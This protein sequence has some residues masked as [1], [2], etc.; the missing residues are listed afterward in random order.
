MEGETFPLFC[1]DE[2]HAVLHSK[3]IHLAR[4]KEAVWD[5]ANIL[6]DPVTSLGNWIKP[7]LKPA[8]WVFSDMKQ[9]TPL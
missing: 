2:A 1:Y 3:S 9:Q 4:R 6:K 8:L 7:T 5:E